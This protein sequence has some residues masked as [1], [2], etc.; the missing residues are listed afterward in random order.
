MQLCARLRTIPP[1]RSYQEGD[2]GNRKLPPL[3]CRGTND[4]IVVFPE[5]E[6]VGSLADNP[7]QAALPLPPFLAVRPAVRTADEVSDATDDSDNYGSSDDEATSLSARENTAKAA[8]K[9]AFDQAARQRRHM[10]RTTSTTSDGNGNGDGDGGDLPS[11]QASSGSA[12]ARPSRGAAVK[13][14][15]RLADMASDDDE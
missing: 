3:T 13:A 2:P 12:S 9:R 1:S 4:S 14:R 15:E 5:Y 10:S 7:T 8:A 6:W 11:S